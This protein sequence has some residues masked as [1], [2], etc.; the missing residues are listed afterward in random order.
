MSDISSARIR[1]KKKENE[2]KDPHDSAHAPL[3]L[4]NAHNHKA[5]EEEGEGN[6]LVSYADM[7]TLLVGFF[8]I[9]LSFSVMDAKKFEE[10]KQSITQEFG[11]TYTVPYAALADKIK[12][13]AKKLG[14]GDQFIIKESEIGIEISSRGTVFFNTGSADLKDEAKVVLSNF[15]DVVRDQL[16]EFDITIEGHTDD[17]P[18]MPGGQYRN[19]WE[20]SSL[21]ACR[22]LE[23]FMSAG[24][25]KERLTAAG[26]GE[27]RPLVPNRDA[28][29][30]AIAENQSQNRR[31]VIK[32]MKHADPSLIKSEKQAHAAPA[33]GGQPSEIPAEQRAPA[34]A[35][36][37]APANPAAAPAPAAEAP[38][39]P[40]AETTG[41]S[42]PAPSEAPV[43]N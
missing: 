39:P 7:M 19:N 8:V 5:H 40:P 16:S 28:E 34:Q 26:Y 3:A 36:D 10:A 41:A 33:P 35:A 14:V 18:I 20:L 4:G 21:R 25:S 15:I 32:L 11:G 29:G 37:A 17:V 6:W 22:V 13:A 24:I 30:N 23:T 42:L 12:E 38:A 31:V 9:L 2:D 1:R 27:A 43:A